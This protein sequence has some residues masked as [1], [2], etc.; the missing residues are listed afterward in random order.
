MNIKVK[1]NQTNDFWQN[2]FFFS[3]INI[4]PLAFVHFNVRVSE[5]SYINILLLCF[6]VLLP[7]LFFKPTYRLHYLRI[8][9]IFHLIF[10]T[11]SLFYA[12]VFKSFISKHIYYVLFDTH[13]AETKEFLADFL[14]LPAMVIL[15]I[16]LSLAIYFILKILP[17]K[18]NFNP[19]NKTMYFFVTIP[20]LFNLSKS[21]FKPKKI[22]KL[23]A[24]SSSPVMFMRSFSHYIISMKELKSVGETKVTIPNVKTIKKKT[25]ETHIFI[26][27]EALTTIHMSLYGYQ[28]QTNPLLESIK[29]ELFVFQNV[30]CS[31]PPVTDI[32]IQRILTL[33]D[34][35]KDD[36]D[37]L[38]FNLFNFMRSAGFKTYWISNQGSIGHKLNIINAIALSSDEQY[39]TSADNRFNIDDRIFNSFDTVLTDQHPL[40][41]IVIHINGS[42]NTYAHRYPDDFNKWKAD[43]PLP[44]KRSFHTKKK[45]KILNEYDNSVLFNDFIIFK[46]IERLRKLE[47]QVSLTY[48][49]DHGEEV[50]ETED[51]MG[52]G[53]SNPT[54]GLYSI[55]FI[56]WFNS[57]FIQENSRIIEA[58]KDSTEKHFKTDN[59]LHSYLPLLNIQH[60]KLIKTKNLYSEDFKKNKTF[61]FSKRHP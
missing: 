36:N 34:T 14:T 37:L 50:Y 5:E 47:S 45:I 17:K 21:D 46:I 23:Y 4:I 6:L 52:H 56:H 41:L 39:Y 48:F 25:T 38:K 22:I 53:G 61:K 51:R 60:P 55:P 11:I 43:S 28:R 10:N 2:Y 35:K 31:S 8:A 49:P 27:G 57:R 1:F 12:I 18:L 3:L 20:L 40:K 16:Y 58:I 9:Y 19:A 7:S 24:K 59:F 54:V 32:N 29:D 44:F 42:H 13:L 15:S 33:K 30:Q 26:I